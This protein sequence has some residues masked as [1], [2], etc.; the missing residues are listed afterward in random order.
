M[1]H[2][3]MHSKADNFKCKICGENFTTNWQLED[4]EKEHGDKPY[5]CDYPNC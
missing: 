4:H 1:K 2:I 3:E 5:E